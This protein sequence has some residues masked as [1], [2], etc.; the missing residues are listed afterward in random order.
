LANVGTENT[1]VSAVGQS[2]IDLT[3]HSPILRDRIGGWRVN[4]AA[5]TNSDHRRIEFTLD[6]RATF[7]RKVRNYE[8]F[9]WIKWY[10]LLQGAKWA[11]HTTWNPVK[12]EQA[13]K[14]FTTFLTN[15]L[16][17]ACPESP[18]THRAQHV[19]YWNE[20]LAILRQGVHRAKN[21]MQDARNI[22]ESPDS[23]P[24]SFEAYQEKLANYRTLRNEFSKARKQ[25][26][27]QADR[28]RYTDVHKVKDFAKLVNSLRKTKLKNVGLIR[29][30]EGNLAENSEETIRNLMDAHFPGATPPQIQSHPPIPRDVP[31]RDR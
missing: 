25:A 30:A 6:T 27:I 5:T 8:K 9:D 10:A 3:I 19:Y 23:S 4:T 20:E 28:K 31:R 1:F 22:H 24:E 13:A 29:D 11:T 7:A 14:K 17:Q 12:L 18:L 16:D 26:K 21:S 2:I 15:S